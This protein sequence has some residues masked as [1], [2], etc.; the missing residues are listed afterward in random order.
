MLPGLALLIGALFTQTGC[1]VS[2]PHGKG[3]MRTVVE[4]TTR[5][6]Y[7]LYLPQSY[8]QLDPLARKQRRWPLVVTFHG[9]KPFDHAPWQVHEWEAEADRF[10]FIVVA[11]E[12]NAPDVLAEFPLKRV[13]PAMKRDEEATLAIIRHV[14]ATTEADPGNVLS[15]GF[16]SGGYMAHYMLNRHPDVFTCLAARQGNFSTSVQDPSLAP[17]SQRT[18]ILIVY[19]EN[20]MGICKKESQDAITWY[21]RN[22]FTNV[23]WVRL[24]ALGH[25]RTPDLAADFFGRAAGVSPLRPPSTLANRQAMAGNSRGLQFMSGQMGSNRVATGPT[26]SADVNTV[27]TPP[28]AAACEPY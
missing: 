18:P 4:P 25:V 9:M 28:P 16:S 27:R 17:R 12:L 5:R 15:T 20:D 2:Q 19:T 24:K 11:P 22:G 8:T 10:G 1:L 7:H 3:E 6:T 21:E 13:H 23:G 14:F 26:P